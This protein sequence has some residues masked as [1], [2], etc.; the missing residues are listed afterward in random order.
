MRFLMG[1]PFLEI[2]LAVPN[3]LAGNAK[4]ASC[5]ILAVDAEPF[6]LL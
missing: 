3:A 6:I 2:L 1:V 5:A 4:H